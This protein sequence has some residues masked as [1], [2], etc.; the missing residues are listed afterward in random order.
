MKQL[1]KPVITILVILSV[2]VAFLLLKRGTYAIDDENIVYSRTDLENM[3]VS[4]ALSYYYNHNYSDY[5]QKEMDDA[6]NYYWRSFIT[7][8]EMVSRSNI[9]AI[10]CSSFAASVYL[11]SFGYDLSDYAKNPYPP[12]ANWVD[13]SEGT[14]REKYQHRYLQTGRGASTYFMG[15]IAE[16]ISGNSISRNSGVE[17]INNDVESEVVYYYPVDLK[18]VNNNSANGES[19]NINID[20][21]DIEDEAYIDDED[22]VVSN[23]ICN[24]NIYNESCDKMN[25]IKSNIINNLRPGD[26]FIYRKLKSETNKSGHVMVYVG[27]ALRT[28][29]KG[30]IHATGNDFKL[31]YEERGED[32]YSIKYDSWEKIQNNLFVDNSSSPSYDYIILRPINTFCNGDSCTL[33]KN[34]VKS[35]MYKRNYDILHNNTIARNELSRLRVEQY[36]FRGDNNAEII[37]KYNSLNIGDEISYRVAVT[38][39]SKMGYCRYGDPRYNSETACTNKLGADYWNEANAKI[40]DY[41]ITISGTIPNGT[42]FVSCENNCT[43]DS[44]NGKVTWRNIQMTSNSTSAQGYTY[45]VRVVSGNKIEN[46]GMQIITNDNHTLQLASLTTFINS[47]ISKESDVVNMNGVIDEL[48]GSHMSYASDLDLAKNIYNNAFEIDLSSLTYDDMKTAIFDQEG[49]NYKKRTDS[50]ISSMTGNNKIINDMLVSGLYGGRKLAGNDNLDRAT[51][52]TKK[53]IFKGARKRTFEVGDIL[54][55]YDVDNNSNAYIFIGY[56]DDENYLF[57]TYDNDVVLISG[58]DGWLV[59]KDMYATSLFFVLRPT[60][61]YPISTK[62]ILLTSESLYIDN[63]DMFISGISVRTN[64]SSFKNLLTTN[65]SMEIRNKNSQLKNDEDYIV[66]GDVLSVTYND[67]TFTYLLLVTGDV[68]GD[69]VVD[70]KDAKA[71][72]NHIV[73]RNSISSNKNIL[74]GDMNSDGKIKMNDAMLL[75][76]GL[77][78]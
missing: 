10:D 67:E 52:T 22:M 48:M 56:D 5:E 68:N 15:N 71:I 6:K 31:T 21:V 66:T 42:E 12:Y 49:V 27:E 18:T 37:N 62:G 47:T 20:E 32:Y 30:F 7:S 28:G 57:V 39:K 73:N 60:K 14:T 23:T 8:P 33:S 46:V 75:V 29:E 17:W 54:V 72:A 38:N 2:V 53:N 9:F 63:Q 3:A 74:A 16:I 26:L 36:Q 76:N 40:E 1:R 65:G 41:V 35:D 25:E 69:G 61:V 13:D 45:K 24:E 43:Y 64:G 44:Q 19:A 59:T 78:K 11:Y 51:V 55:T 4:T 50:F 70:I 58:H 34:K 77:V